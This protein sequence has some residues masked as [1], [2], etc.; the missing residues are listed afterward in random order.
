MSL[1]SYWV[2][3][4]PIGYIL[5]NFVH[6]GPDGYWIGLISGLALGAIGLAMRLRNIQKKS[7]H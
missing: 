6:M 1:V 7:I 4:L 3:G 2:L 5:A